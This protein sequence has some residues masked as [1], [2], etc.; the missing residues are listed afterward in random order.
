MTEEFHSSFALSSYFDHQCLTLMVPRQKSINVATI[1]YVS[2]K[3]QIWLY[4]GIAFLSIT[5]I[6]TGISKLGIHLK[7]YKAK[8]LPF[9]NLSNAFT[10]VINTATTHGM[11]NFH[12][13]QT[14][15]KFVAFSWIIFSSI[16]GV[17]YSSRYVT[18]LTKPPLTEPID[19]VEDFLTKD[20]LIGEI[21]RAEMWQS[22]LKKYNYSIYT[23]L[24]NQFKYE[25]SSLVRL[26]NIKSGRYGYMVAKLSNQFIANIPLRNT[27][28]LLPMRLM[29]TCLMNYFS[30]LAF[31]PQSPFCEYFSIKLAK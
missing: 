13:F 26:E 14:S 21:D 16:F 30:S 7:M 25:E 15:I 6:L 27:T 5:F 22:L 23:T 19:K 3:S 31:A 12:S 24:S 18:L 4:F 11:N 29:K 28:K 17:M 9:R 1:I 8:D 20:F 2:L 10:E